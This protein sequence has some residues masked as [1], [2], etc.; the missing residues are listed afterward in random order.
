VLTKTMT[1][2]KLLWTAAVGGFLA[3]VSGT[4]TGSA[5]TLEAVASSVTVVVT[6]S[7]TLSLEEQTH[8][9]GR[10]LEERVAC[11]KFSKLVHGSGRR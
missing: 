3:A 6:P 8:R 1:C 10:F 9:L 5:Q 7:Q 11:V 4:R 2:K